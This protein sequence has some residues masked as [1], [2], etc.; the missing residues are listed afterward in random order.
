MLTV[1]QFKEAIAAQGSRKWKPNALDPCWRCGGNLWRYSSSMLWQGHLYVSLACATCCP[2]ATTWMA[3]GIHPLQ[4]TQE[5][6]S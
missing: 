6:K 2:A 1:E 3:V 4:G 5:A